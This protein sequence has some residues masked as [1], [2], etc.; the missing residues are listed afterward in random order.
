MCNKTK[1][2]ETIKKSLQNRRKANHNNYHIYG[3]G[4]DVGSRN[5]TQKE[6]ARTC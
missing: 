3:G 1:R 4:H 5:G 6:N 2:H